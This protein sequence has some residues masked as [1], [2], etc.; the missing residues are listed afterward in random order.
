MREMKASYSTG[1]DR[2]EAVFYSIPSSCDC[3]VCSRLD[4]ILL[5]NLQL[6]S[7]KSLS[8][9]RTRLQSAGYRYC[10]PHTRYDI[11]SL[12]PSQARPDWTAAWNLLTMGI[13]PPSSAI[14][15]RPQGYALSNLRGHEPTMRA[16]VGSFC[17][18]PVRN[19]PCHSP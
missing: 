16:L 7:H 11:H 4:L 17:D 15:P 13:I 8:R 2:V 9:Q 12:Q 14:K 10:S 5:G 18:K 1:T 6:C 3:Y 19:H